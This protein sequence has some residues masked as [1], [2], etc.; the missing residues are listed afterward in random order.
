MLVSISQHIP[1]TSPSRLAYISKQHILRLNMSV[2]EPV[3]LQP[4]CD[5][6]PLAFLA[7]YPSSVT[8]N[9]FCHVICQT[10]NRIATRCKTSR[11]V[12]VRNSCDLFPWW[13]RFTGFWIRHSNIHLSI[14][15]Y[16]RSSEPAECYQ[17]NNPHL[18]TVKDCFDMFWYVLMNYNSF[19]PQKYW[20]LLQII[21]R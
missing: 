10:G 14:S 4:I 3:Q 6:S 12:L 1:K 16:Q 7:Q 15:W 9:S 8:R 21:H 11:F 17:Q 2:V 18:T 19:L 20:S 13:Y 5:W